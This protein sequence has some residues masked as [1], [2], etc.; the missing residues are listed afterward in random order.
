MERLTDLAELTTPFFHGI[1]APKDFRLGVELEYFLVQMADLA[2]VSYNHQVPGIRDVF[3]ALIRQHGWSPV[4][5]GPHII[6][7]Q[8]GQE[9]LTLEPG[10]AIEYSSPPL[11]TLWD[12]ERAVTQCLDEVQRVIKPMRLGLLP[13]GLHPFARPESVPLVP[14]ER[15]YIMHDYMPTVGPTG[16]HMMKLTCSAQVTIDYY[17]EADALRKMQLAAKLTPFLVALSA[18]SPVREGTY[19]GLASARAHTWLGT[20]RLRTGFPD[21]V[22]YKHPSFM[23]YVDWALDVPLYFLE[24]QGKKLRVGHPTFRA[25]FENGIHLPRDGGCTYATMADWQHHLSTVF[26]WVRLR[27]Y[28]EI[29]AFDINTPDIV[30][31][32]AALLKGLFYSQSALNAVEALVGDYDRQT[33]ETLLHEAIFYG[34][35]AEV[36]GISF[37]DMVEYCIDLAKDGLCD[38]GLHEYVFL[39]PF[40]SLAL[41]HRTDDLALMAD[42]H[43]ERYVRSKLL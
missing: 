37:H 21:C 38:Q 13:L 32:A 29:R 10:G 43:L 2:M 3:L 25:F 20:D 23:D 9:Q 28:L 15:Y 4:Y 31:A 16:R 39:K 19:A 30:L 12:L 42:L 33:V 11:A 7:L 6:A 41:K 18:N 14:K 40:E 1:T 8:R 35:E 36:D 26:P 24:R 34:L 17:S 5:E 27:E 22:F